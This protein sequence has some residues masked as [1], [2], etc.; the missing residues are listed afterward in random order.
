MQDQFDLNALGRQIV[1]ADTP[2]FAYVIQGHVQSWAMQQ[3]L[4]V[5]GLARFNRK[6]IDE[7]LQS[8]EDGKEMVSFAMELTSTGW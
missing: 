1:S 3:Q 7:I 4:L 2:V 5:F 6:P 8:A